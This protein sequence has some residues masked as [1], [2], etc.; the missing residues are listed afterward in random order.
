MAL[1]EAALKK[2]TKDKIIK[3]TLELQD[4]VNQDLKCKRISLN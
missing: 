1:T 4:N 2:L 3:L